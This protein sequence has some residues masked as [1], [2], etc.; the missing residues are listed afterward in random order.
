M[1]LAIDIGNTTVALCGLKDGRVCFETHLNSR[2]QWTA[3]ACRKAMEEAFLA[4]KLGPAPRFEG[5]VLTS[6]VPALTPVFSACAE[7]FTPAPAL[8]AGP[9]LVTGL[10]MDVRYPEKVGV[11]RIVDAAAAARYYPLPVITV[12][13]GTCTTF[14]VVDEKGVFR[15]GAIAPGLS[16]GL[17]T[18]HEKTAQLPLVR[19]AAPK[20]AIGKDTESCI[21][22]GAVYGAAAL[23]DGMAARFEEELGCPATLVVTGGHSRWVA[24][25]CHHPLT[26]D[27]NL[28]MKGL[29]LLWELNRG[30]KA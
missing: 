5:A 28:M 16:T 9:A 4:C 19:P 12:D 17:R 25:L 29:A 2:T 8:V 18:L 13:M 20:T 3:P 6:V 30:K 21:L 22:S 7:A 27:E 11:D 10:I 26:R 24:P 14:N 1:I 15:G 23:I